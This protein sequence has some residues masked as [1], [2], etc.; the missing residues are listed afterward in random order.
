MSYLVS[1]SIVPGLPVT[2]NL[3]NPDPTFQHQKLSLTSQSHQQQQPS[4]RSKITKY[5]QSL[6]NTTTTTNLPPPHHRTMSI[7]SVNVDSSTLEKSRAKASKKVLNATLSSK[8]L[9]TDNERN[10]ISYLV[11]HNKYF[12]N[13]LNCLN[14]KDL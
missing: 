9:T 11:E 3:W 5:L 13:S 10:E 1:N 7:K 4:L 6:S 2:W 14:M 12:S 8:S